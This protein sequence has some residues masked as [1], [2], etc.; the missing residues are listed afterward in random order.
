M[1]VPVNNTPVPI[2]LQ[3]IEL[4]EI[5]SKPFLEEIMKTLRLAFG[6]LLALATGTSALLLAGC[7]HGPAPA[8]DESTTPATLQRAAAQASNAL[9]WDLYAHLGQKKGN[10][11]FS[12]ASVELA[13]AMTSTGAGGRTAEEMHE[14]L[15]LQA[16]GGP[17]RVSL[18]FG[19]LQR[20]LLSPERACTLELANALWGQEGFTF[21]PGF[22]E[23]L[24]MD[25][26]ARLHTMDFQN[27]P[28]PARAALNHWVE[29]QTNA[30]I[31]DLFP[32]GS[33][34]PDTRLVLANAVYFL[35]QWEYPF[36]G[37]DTRDRS[38]HLS[39]D[40]S[41]AVPTM[42]QTDHFSYGEVPGAQVLVLPYQD[43]G[44]EMVIVLPRDR[45]GLPALEKNLSNERLQDWVGA[46]APHKVEVLL[47]RFTLEGSF[48]LNTTL[49]GL[50]MATA[51]SRGADFTG[52]TTHAPLAISRVVHKSFIDVYEKGTEAAAATGVAIMTTSMP[53]QDLELVHFVADH[54]FLFFIRDGETGLVLFL[55]R[56]ADPR[57]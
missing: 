6:I 10:L 48:D 54:P 15:H 17:D 52:M 12:P 39:A 32:A 49:A 24:E 7:G 53:A 55:G 45:D 57:G 18:A 27:R 40:E 30:K 11:F 42:K 43:C 9:G 20:K 36:K 16:L 46:L 1:P 33:I 25:F 47:P 19:G 44:L 38:F 8:L 34:G 31:K 50:G 35:G 4:N 21:Q 23:R 5:E 13:L 26:E 14:V 56:V 3:T 41:I 37:W 29:Q 2:V 22:L 51:F 28:E